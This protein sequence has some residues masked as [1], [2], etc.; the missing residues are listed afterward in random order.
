MTSCFEPVALVASA[1]L[2]FSISCFA[3]IDGETTL[4]HESKA[5]F[6]QLNERKAHPYDTELETNQHH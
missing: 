4:A 5:R 6:R 1:K 2:G 3:V